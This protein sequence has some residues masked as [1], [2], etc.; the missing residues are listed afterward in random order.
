M[1]VA[2]QPG[3]VVHGAGVDLLILAAGVDLLI[4]AACG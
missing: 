1:D 2:G 3:E 4:L